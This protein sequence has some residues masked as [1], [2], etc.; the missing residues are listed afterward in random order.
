MPRPLAQRLVESSKVDGVESLATFFA[1]KGLG[2]KFRYAR[3]LLF[4]QPSFMMVQYGLTHRR[5]LGATYVR[6]IYWFS[7]QAAK[8]LARLYPGGAH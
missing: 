2:A 5:Q 3:A 6:R 8:G 1:I 4:P 7:W